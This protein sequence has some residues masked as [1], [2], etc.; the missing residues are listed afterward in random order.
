MRTKL[1]FTLP[2]FMSPINQVQQSNNAVIF[3]QQKLVREFATKL[4][5]KNEQ[6]ETA[7]TRRDKFILSEAASK[8]LT[9]KLS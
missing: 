8:L 6:R 7:D 4:A 2:K 1:V 5:D 3:A 9:A